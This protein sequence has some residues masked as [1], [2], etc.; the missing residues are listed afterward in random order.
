MKVYEILEGSLLPKSNHIDRDCECDEKP[1]NSDVAKRIVNKARG[2]AKKANPG[3]GDTV[4]GWRSD[5][6]QGGHVMSF[7]NR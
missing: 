4:S 1:T 6:H 3:D 2:K 7:I 5:P